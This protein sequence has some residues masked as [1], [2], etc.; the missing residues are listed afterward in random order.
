MS[1]VAG[2]KEAFHGRSWAGDVLSQ[3]Q[4][5]AG[6]SVMRAVG[7][8][9]ESRKSGSLEQVGAKHREGETEAE[10]RGPTAMEAGRTRAVP[11]PHRPR[12][13]ALGCQRGSIDPRP[14]SQ[15]SGTLAPRMCTAGSDTLR[16]SL[17]GCWLQMPHPRFLLRGRWGWQVPFT[18]E[19][20]R[21]GEQS[22]LEAW[23]RMAV[24]PLCHLPECFVRCHPPHS[25]C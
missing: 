22:I 6:L 21:A 7:T 20:G 2:D 4:G 13:A 1:G 9:Q 10:Q 5:G 18:A 17:E 16:A 25:G 8:L 15:V 19:T 11:R 24:S 14:K 23:T 12:P 3:G